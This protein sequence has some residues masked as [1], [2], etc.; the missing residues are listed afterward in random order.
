M[1]LFKV[2]GSKPYEH[3]IRANSALEAVAVCNKDFP[4]FNATQAVDTT[5]DSY[6]KEYDESNFDEQ[7]RRKF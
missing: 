5:T 6:Q 3:L 2:Y 1:I 7:G 4:T